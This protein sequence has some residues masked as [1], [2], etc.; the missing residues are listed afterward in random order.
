MGE[1]VNL[2]HKV[3]SESWNHDPPANQRPSKQRSQRPVRIL[4]A[5]LTIA[6]MS[7]A[8]FLANVADA[9]PSKWTH[10]Y[11]PNASSYQ[12][13][14]SSVTCTSVTSC[15]AVGQTNSSSN[16]MPLVETWNGSAWSIRSITPS[17]QSGWLYGVSCISEFDCVAVG[18]RFAS[19]SLI[20]SSNSGSWKVVPS[21]NMGTESRLYAVSCISSTDTCVAVGFY[22]NA[23]MVDQTL[24]ESWN[25]KKWSVTPS[26]NVADAP[27]LLQGVSCITSTDCFAVGY[28]PADVGQTL[29]ES[30]NGS[31]WSIVPSPDPSSETNDLNGVSCASSHS[32]VAVGTFD[33]DS[34][35]V[36]EDLIETWDGTSWSATPTPEPEGTFSELSAVSCV[37]SKSCVA[38]G[39]YVNES[40]ADVTV[41]ESLAGAVWSIDESPNPG[42]SDDT[43]AGARCT[44]SD[45]CVAVG[46]F[47]NTGSRPRTL[48]ES[49]T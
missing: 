26:P 39:D 46:D 29:I 22:V 10:I 12:N 40:E 34:A 21:P 35:G 38:V 2:R 9:A 43:L 1:L 17:D 16:G 27:N 30:W 4:G 6:L 31:V 14:L 37:S 36:D 42:N 49:G 11:S 7:N 20:M 48:V 44:S 47:L 5:F 33:D 18:S 41:I 32:C 24:I 25:G 8:I 23:S 28:V 19:K 13:V 3:L 45:S 15:T